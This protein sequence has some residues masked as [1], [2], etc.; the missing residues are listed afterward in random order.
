MSSSRLPHLAPTLF[1][2]A[3]AVASCANPKRIE[4]EPIALMRNGDRVDPPVRA[5][6]DATTQALEAGR[7]M[8]ALPSTLERVLSKV[9]AGQIEL[10]FAENGRNG[11]SR[12]RRAP[13]PASG[14]RVSLAQGAMFVASIAA[15]TLLLLN[16]ALIP[17][18]FCLGLAGLTAVG[19]LAGSNAWV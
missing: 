12:L 9:E 11:T 13:N 8:L 17:G 19:G 3:F 4:E 7:T 1:M 14:E 6:D 15:G 18:W 16:Q 5:I 10:R 2:T